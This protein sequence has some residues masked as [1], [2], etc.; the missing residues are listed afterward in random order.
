MIADKHE[1][2]STNTMIYPRT[3][4]EIL[5]ALTNITDLPVH[6]MLHNIFRVLRPIRMNFGLS[7]NESILLNGI[8]LYS[9]S[10]RGEFT[11][12]TIKEWAGYW[13]PNKIQYYISSLEKK[14]VIQVHSTAG[15]RIYYRITERG[16][17][18]CR[19]LLSDYN[20]IVSSYLSKFN[21]SI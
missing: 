11:R 15:K 4:A 2:S 7:V 19:M 10:V 17:Y 12:G 8:Y 5:P 14:G 20:K 9:L 16:L 3:P 1:E 13:N 18:I 21:L 6:I